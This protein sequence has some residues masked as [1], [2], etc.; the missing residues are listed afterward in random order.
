MINDLAT[1]AVAITPSNGADLPTAALG[2]YVGVAGDVKVDMVNGNEGIVFKAA[3][4]GILRVHAKKVYATG[5]T[6]TNLVALK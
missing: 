6:A 1:G 2:I 4:V 5:T 3:P